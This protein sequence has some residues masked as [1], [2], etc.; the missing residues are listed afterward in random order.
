MFAY[1]RVFEA[2]GIS[3]FIL[4][5]KRCPVQDLGFGKV[6]LD[7]GGHYCI[8]ALIRYDLFSVQPSMKS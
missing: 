8:S 3:T 4:N 5:F 1:Q 6:D 2:L 7:F